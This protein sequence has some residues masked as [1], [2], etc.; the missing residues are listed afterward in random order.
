MTKQEIKDFLT[1]NQGYQKKSSIVIAR[2]LF[3]NNLKEKDLAIV[4]ESIREL[5]YGEEKP[6]RV[7][8]FDI[9]TSPNTCLSWSVGPK[10]SLSAESI[11]EERAIICVCWK[12]SDE[13]EVHSLEWN[14]G[15]DKE[16]C[17]KFAKVL[18]SAE[19][20]SGHNIKNFDL[21]WIRTRCLMH[22]IELITNY[23]VA[24]TLTM[25]RS[26]FNFNSNKLDYIS[27]ILGNTGKKSTSYDLWKNIILK[28]DKN[29]MATMVDYCKNDILIQESVYYKLSKYV[30]SKTRR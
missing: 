25:A 2:R 18:N 20:V 22:D 9:E 10:I 8:F 28:N 7:L 30:P 12:W 19:I 23:T 13:T 17:K 4:K 3:G 14:K 21:K 27:K 26:N 5:K 6:K 11:I 1:S 15:D 24:D 29:A 16:L